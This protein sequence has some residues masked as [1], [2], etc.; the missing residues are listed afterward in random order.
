[1]LKKRGVTP[2]VGGMLLVVL[3]VSLGA[4]VFVWI[5]GYTDKTGEGNLRVALCREVDFDVGDVCYE[6]LSEGSTEGLRIEFNAINYYSGNLNGF[7]IILDYPGGTSA[8]VVDVEIEPLF[9]KV[10][11]TGFIEK[12]GQINRIRIV[13]RLRKL[14]DVYNCDE[15]EIVRVWS[16]VKSCL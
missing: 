16:E 4:I 13:P 1:M 6:E 2:I 11:S 9:T 15:R 3:V 10:I 8:D 14:N 5:R 7:L 12:R